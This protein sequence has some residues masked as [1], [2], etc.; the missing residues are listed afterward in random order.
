MY[1]YNKNS[2]EKSTYFIEQIQIVLIVEG[3][4]NS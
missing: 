3:I 2:T 4:K 1:P